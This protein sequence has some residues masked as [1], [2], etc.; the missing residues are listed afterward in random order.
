M[1]IPLIYL[2]LFSAIASAKAPLRL[3]AI[4][5]DHAVLQ[6]SANVKLWGWGP[7]SHQIAIIGS[8]NTS[9]TVY[10]KFGADFTWETT[11]KT[12]KGGGETYEIAF[13]CNNQ[14]LIIK[15]ILL[16]EV[17]LCGGQSNMEYNFNWGGV[18]DV[19]DQQNAFTNNNQIRF[20]KV[21]MSYFGK[22]PQ[23]DCKGEWKVCNPNTA[24][25]FSSVGY[26]FGKNLQE[27]IK[28]PIGLIGSYVGGT[29][30]QTWCPKELFDDNIEQQRIIP[31][32]FDV[33][34]LPLLPFRT[35]NTIYFSK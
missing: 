2:I 4:I 8:W 5:S 12:P 23:E 26:F 34:G 13:L 32:L 7:G 3:P 15:D 10:A 31:N 27:V 6:Q 25:D 33:N 11:I 22:Y 18:S 24:K 28:A 19:V 17:W 21:A 1:K 16:G 30:I 35:D 9:D 14:K 20:F 29:C